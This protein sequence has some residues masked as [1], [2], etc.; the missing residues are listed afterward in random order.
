MKK[1]KPSPRK[2]FWLAIGL[3]M[4]ISINA[5]YAAPM[6]PRLLVNH[7]THQCA[8]ITPGDECGD[9]IVPQDWEFLVASSDN[10]CP[11]NYTQID[12]KLEW[13]HFKSQFCCSEGHSGSAGDC[14]DVVTQQSSRQCAF[15]EDLQQCASLPEGWKA[16]GQNC[17]V[18][19]SWTDNIACTS[20]ESSPIAKGTGGIKTEPTRSIQPTD[21]PP[22]GL[23]QPTI[24][25]TAR[26]PLLPCGS[27]GLALLG[28]FLIKIWQLR[29]A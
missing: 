2:A 11:D 14:E 24:S 28:L 20:K 21:T 18:D 17:P 16:L 12:L 6:P 7:K 19:F 4:L 25:P 13:K 10:K 5:A 1:F 15:V 3:S 23:S 22:A 8:Q 9:V 27:S 29:K 26:N